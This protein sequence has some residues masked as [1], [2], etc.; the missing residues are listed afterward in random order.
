MFLAKENF[1]ENCAQKQDQLLCIIFAGF[2]EGTE[3]EY[4]L[5]SMF[6][7]YEYSYFTERY[8]AM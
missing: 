5:F 2:S 8:I 6:F 7:L 1:F 3:G 4:K